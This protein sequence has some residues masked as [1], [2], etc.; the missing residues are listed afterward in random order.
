MTGVLG[1]LVSNG[2]GA[3]PTFVAAGA[4][5]YEAPVAGTLQVPYP[6]S[7]IAGQFLVLHVVSQDASASITT[8]SGWTLI[9][10]SAALVGGTLS[11]VYWKKAAGTESGN[12]DVTL[13]G[14]T[15]CGGRIY[16]FSRGSGVEAAGT[17]AETASDSDITIQNVT[18]L[19]NRRLACQCLWV[20]NNT[21]MADITGESGANYA[22]AVAEYS[23][24]GLTLGL[25][26]AVVNTPTAIT[27]GTCVIGT[28]TSN[29]IAHGF[30]IKS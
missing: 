27:G 22:E 21:T 6:A 11:A 2:A 8:P 4:G 23:N 26:T 29:K 3:A 15:R 24:T 19:G 12:L 30:A 20:Q 13:T 14:G 5:G 1:V 9:T 28:A 7:I 25:Q 18:T 16:Q 10:D 17:I